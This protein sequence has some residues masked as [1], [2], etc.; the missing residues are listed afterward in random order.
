M[1][2][3]SLDQT[4]AYRWSIRCSNTVLFRELPLGRAI[5]LARE[6]AR[7]EHLHSRRD[8]CVEMP[9]IGGPI[10]LASYARQPVDETEVSSGNSAAA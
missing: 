3:V 6:I 7:Y 9:G 2:L 1:M 5:A 8:T 4:A 10:R